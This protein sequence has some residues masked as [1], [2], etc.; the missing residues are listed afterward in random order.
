MPQRMHVPL[1]LLFGGIFSNTFVLHIE[2]ICRAINKVAARAKAIKTSILFCS[3]FP[4]CHQQ[5]DNTC[6]YYRKEYPVLPNFPLH[7]IEK[8]PK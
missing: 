7:N 1:L 5:N 8:Y 4:C 6:K 3:S 2:N